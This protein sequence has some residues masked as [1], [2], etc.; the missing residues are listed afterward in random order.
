MKR[1]LSSLLT[2]YFKVLLPSL[3]ISLFGIAVIGAFLENDSSASA[4]PKFF[5]LALWIS[6]TAFLYWLCIR[7]KNVSIDNE[8]LYVSNYL[9][10]IT[11]PLS[12]IYFVTENRWVNIHPVTIHLRSPSEFGDKITFMPK[13]RLFPFFGS[14]PVVKELKALPKVEQSDLDV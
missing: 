8:F 6:G 12:N 13:I 4:P 2:L 10:E 14:H 9:K 3:W 5:L 7:L 1:N 11:I